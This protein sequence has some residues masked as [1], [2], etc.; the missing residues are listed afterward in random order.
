[1]KTTKL[2]LF[3]FLLIASCKLQTICSAQP[4]QQWVSSYNG[5]ANQ[6]DYGRAIQVDTAGNSYIAGTVSNSGTAKDIAVVKYNSLGVQQWVATYNG[7][8]NSEEWAYCLVL[9][10]AGNIYTAGFTNTT[11]LGKNFITVK[12]DSVGVFQ[13]AMQYDGTGNSDDAANHI[14]VD[15]WGNIAVTGISKGSGTSDDYATV[16]YSPQGTQLWVARYDGPASAVDDART[17]TADK[18]G[19]FYVSGG[20][21]GIASDYDYATIKY[22]SAGV[23]Q[24]CARYNGPKN[25]YDLVYYQ[26]SVVVDTLGNVYITGYSTGTDSTLDYVTIKYDSNGSQLWLARYFTQVGGTDYADAI[27]VDDSLNVYVTG[28]SFKTGNDY[29]FA[30]VKYNSQGV[31][32]WVATYNGT[33]NSWDEAYGVLTD[34]SLNVY[35]VGRSPGTNTS[36]DFLTLKYSPAGNKMWEVRYAHNGYDWPFNIRIS[37][38]RSIYVG[39]WT[40]PSNGMPDMTI[41]KYS[42]APL[43]IENYAGKTKELEIFPNPSNGNFTINFNSELRTPDLQLTI[44]NVMGEKL[45]EQTV[46]RKQETLNLKLPDGIYFIR[47]TSEAITTSNKLIITSKN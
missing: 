4:L 33:G 44:Y 19:N 27:H 41:V 38:D 42:Q 28:G 3:I 39:G 14:A 7:T 40:S 6:L 13:W 11:S 45:F 29:E 30:T 26:G 10:K 37:S 22:D 2:L 47:V 18:N 16:K 32:Q 24:W 9:D 15:P 8:A 1:M 46:N 31:Q 12:F 25:G 43:G 23:Q 35:I 21:T 5:T 34:D 17:I 20:S 36:A